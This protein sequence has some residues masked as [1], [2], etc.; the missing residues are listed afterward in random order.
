MPSRSVPIAAVVRESIAGIERRTY[1]R[2][3]RES[4]DE[5]AQ[6][7]RYLSVP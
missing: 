5:M 1:E 4:E 2:C 3:G 7:G 6:H